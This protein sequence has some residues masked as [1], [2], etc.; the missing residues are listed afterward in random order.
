MN[1]VELRPL[2][3]QEKAWAGVINYK[4][5]Y[6]DIGP[7]L[8]RSGAQYTGLTK[9]DAERLEKALGYEPGT[10]GPASPFWRD[11][12]VRT[13][14]KPL[15]FDLEDPNDELKY[16][17]CKN[18]KKV[19]A[20]IFE[21]KS[22]AHFV[23]I[24]QEEESKKTNMFNTMKR[25]AIEA[26]GKMSVDEMRKALRLFGKSSENLPP[27]VV[28]NR[29]F[30]IAEGDPEGFL[31]KWVN[32]TSRELQ[33]IIERAVSLNV[34]RKNKRMYMYGTDTLGHGIEETIAFM[35]DPKN[36]DVKFAIQNAI[37]GKSTIDKPLIVKE[38]EIVEQPKEQITLRPVD[39]VKQ[40]IKKDS[41]K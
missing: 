6:E 29:I 5:C 7:Y 13:L 17:Y 37:E 8:T 3:T 24:N 32:N 40:E 19:K 27:S 41:K 35:K 25:K 10:L 22:T 26:T 21:H 36:Q 1:K 34:I 31:N 9:E 28:E 15:Y 20:S 18:H 30:E 2:L 38:P 14:G 12:F 4:N 39:E 16:L 11:Y 33:Y 23:L